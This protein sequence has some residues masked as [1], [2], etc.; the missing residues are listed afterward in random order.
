METAYIFAKS[1]ICSSIFLKV[2]HKIVVIAFILFYMSA[3]LTMSLIP[4]S[5]TLTNK[6]CVSRKTY[7]SC[8]SWADNGWQHKSKYHINKP[9]M[10]INNLSDE[11][12]AIYFM[13]GFNTVSLSTFKVD[14][15]NRLPSGVFS[16]TVEGH[17]CITER[18]PVFLIPVQSKLLWPEM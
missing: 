1:V 10:W 17:V 18:A 9:Q 13:P 15:V 2:T 3:F 7:L 11:R 12:T 14:P 6:K 16:W 5:L 8:W 4:W